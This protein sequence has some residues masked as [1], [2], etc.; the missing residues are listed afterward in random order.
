MWHECELYKRISKMKFTGE[1]IKENEGLP[2]HKNSFSAKE[3]WVLTDPKQALRI[4]DTWPEDE[5]TVHT[6]R[7][8]GTIM[9]C[10]KTEEFVFLYAKPSDKA[11]WSP[12]YQPYALRRFTKEYFLNRRFERIT[13]NEIDVYIKRAKELANIDL[14]LDGHTIKTRKED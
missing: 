11:D 5:L 3:G 10:T 8:G 9:I 7:D 6:Y 4:I 1:F 2:S 12:F 13:K 14:Y